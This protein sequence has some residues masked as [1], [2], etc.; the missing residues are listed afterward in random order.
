MSRP[1]IPPG[2]IKIPTTGTITGNLG[3]QPTIGQI[4]LSASNGGVAAAQ[5]R[6]LFPMFNNLNGAVSFY[7]FDPTSGFDDP[8]ASSV[9]SYRVE[10]VVLGRTPTVSRVMVTYRDLGPVTVMFTLS[11][12]ND[13]Q[14]LVTSANVM[15]QLGNPVPTGK[16]ITAVIGMSLTAANLQLTVTRG[17]GAGPLSISK[18]VLCGRV[19]TQRYA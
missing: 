12:T 1:P 4:I 6:A 11:G 16:L 8:N 10:E 17:A 18:I 9:Y 5:M 15:Q 2:S 14:Q 19:E 3:Q 13:A 7:T